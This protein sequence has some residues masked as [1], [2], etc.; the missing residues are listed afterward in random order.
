MGTFKTPALPQSQQ[1]RPTGSHLLYHQPPNAFTSVGGPSLPT[2]PTLPGQAQQHLLQQQVERQQQL[3]QQQHAA[4]QRY[5]QAQTPNQQAQAAAATTTT[6]TT[7][8]TASPPSAPAQRKRKRTHSTTSATAAARLSPKMASTP[9]TAATVPP[10]PSKD[11]SAKA[12]PDLPHF[13]G[14]DNQLYRCIC[15]TAIEPEEGSS[16]Q[17]ESCLAW[18]HAGCFGLTELDLEGIE[19]FCELCSGRPYRRNEPYIEYCREYEKR[20]LALQESEAPEA[21]ASVVQVAATKKR[22]SAS[23]KAKPR[24]DSISSKMEMEAIPEVPIVESE[25]ATVDAAGP[26]KP[27]R[28]KSSSARS[29][30]TKPSPANQSGPTPERTVRESSAAASAAAATTSAPVVAATT[31]RPDPSTPLRLLEYTRMDRFVFRGSK[32]KADMRRFME[33]WADPEQISLHGS[34]PD[35]EL[36]G[37]FVPPVVREG[38]EDW[39]SS[40]APTYVKLA[41]EGYQLP[42]IGSL[43]LGDE[44]TMVSAE[45][46]QDPVYAVHSSGNLTAG[47][48]IG[49]FFGEVVRAEEYHRDPANQYAEL[50]L[51]KANVRRVGPPVN[52][53]I[54]A[55]C[56]G[57]DMRFIRSGC[58]PNAVI[59]PTLIHKGEAAELAF[60]VY[61]CC[62]IAAGAE[63]LLAW[64]W[65]DQHIVHAFKDSM[66]GAH[67]TR[68]QRRVGLVAAHVL[69]N[70][71]TCACNDLAECAV[72]RIIRFGYGERAIPELADKGGKKLRKTLVDPRSPMGPLIGVKRNWRFGEAQALKAEAAQHE[73]VRLL[74]QMFKPMVEPYLEKEEFEDIVVEQAP[75]PNALVEEA[76]ATGAATAESP[77]SETVE[78]PAVAIAESSAPDVSMEEEDEPPNEAADEPVAPMEVDEQPNDA[79]KADDDKPVVSPSPEPDEPPEPSTLVEGNVLE[80]RQEAPPPVVK[81]EPPGPAS[82]RIRESSIL[83]DPD[84]LTSHGSEAPDDEMEDEEE[85]EEGDRDVSDNDDDDRLSETS[86]LTEPLSHMSDSEAEDD[87]ADE[88]NESLEQ[89]SPSTPQYPA[90]MQT[91]PGQRA[92]AFRR[93]RRVLSPTSPDLSEDRVLT[94]FAD[95]FDTP[96]SGGAKKLIPDA[97]PDLPVAVHE[98]SSK[99]DAVDLIESK[100]AEPVVERKSPAPEN[101]QPAAARSKSP[102]PVPA[103]SPEQPVATALAPKPAAAEVTPTPAESQP[104]PETPALPPHSPTPPPPEPA[105]PPPKKRRIDLKQFMTGGGAKL[106]TDL[107]T[108]TDLPTTSSMSASATPLLERSNV[109]ETA[110]ADSPVIEGSP[111][112]QPADAEL[113]AT[114]AAATTTTPSVTTTPAPEVPWWK[115]SKPANSLLGGLSGLTGSALVEA[116]TPK[117]PMAEPGELTRDERDASATPTA[118]IE[119]H[120]NGRADALS[121]VDQSSLPTESAAVNERL[122]SSSPAQVKKPL[123]GPWDSLPPA[124]DRKDPPPHVAASPEYRRSS[125]SPSPVARHGSPTSPDRYPLNGSRPTWA[126]SREEGSYRDWSSRDRDDRG[127]DWPRGPRTDYRPGSGAVRIPSS[128]GTPSRIPPSAPRGGPFTP[129]GGWGVRGGRGGGAALSG[130]ES[131]RGRGGSP[132]AARGG[133]A[134]G[135]PFPRGR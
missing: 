19:Y 14:F 58:S 102:T 18:Q 121:L 3:A 45:H 66:R 56:Y 7:T 96:I 64:E 69:N 13:M 20:L 31:P 97:V 84:T 83:S 4:M 117:S 128:S 23:K 75:Q 15:G 28:K 133:V 89:K 85:V 93:N 72:A 122:P 48:F 126:S 124:F 74:W 26:P 129:R 12:R 108:P 111:N 90:S 99:A 118:T 60:G 87:D 22:S 104:E 81:I 51:P 61:A 94:P 106:V 1:A 34:D 107:P 42:T 63:I 86:T 37:P 55:R 71:D 27:A 36:L 6:T 46:R 41:E 21:A 135:S 105:P 65:D 88:P 59:R 127:G 123:G 2:P 33:D 43:I 30:K 98:T 38:G 68:L 29:T 109:M 67:A 53:V 17:C 92:S 103:K 50:G 110:A 101:A 73:F 54:D 24:A 49:P 91:P 100:P 16:M 114:I 119:H 78:L 113:Q 70:F 120:P 40:A 32:L 130:G 132:F 62:D 125:R 79:V 77:A 116:L 112:K 9:A 115:Q 131:Y 57:N 82:P 52:V 76:A 39:A 95:G 25:A 44:H 35:F 47:D 80:S 11:G 8:V 134:R 5:V 10:S